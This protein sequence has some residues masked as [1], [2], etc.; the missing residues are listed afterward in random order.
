MDCAKQEW[1]LSGQLIDFFGIIRRLVARSRPRRDLWSLSSELCRTYRMSSFRGIEFNLSR[2]VGGTKPS[3]WLWNILYPSHTWFFTHTRPFSNYTP[4][5]YVVLL[6]LTG[7]LNVYLQKKELKKLRMPG[8]PI[9]F[10]L[11]HYKIDDWANCAIQGTYTNH[12]C[13]ITWYDLLITWFCNSDTTESIRCLG[14]D[15]N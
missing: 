9:H 5:S 4:I 14:L 3:N 7:F 12:H 10:R 11:L 8:Y 15:Y 2:T 6:F 1:F 13:C